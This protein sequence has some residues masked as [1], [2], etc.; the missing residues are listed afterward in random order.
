MAAA[1]RSIATLAA[2]AA[3]SLPLAALGLPLT[4]YLPNY[5]S[6]TLGLTVGMV[7][8][9]FLFVRL[10]DIAFDPFFGAVLDRTGWRM[11]RFKPWLAI[12]VPIVAAASAMLFMA[13]DGVGEL[14]LWAGLVV[15]YGGYSVCVLSHSAW[16]STLSTDYN[17]RSR[18]YAWWQTGNVVGMI[19]VIVLP[20][21]L[22]LWFRDKASLVAVF[23][24]D[25]MSKLSLDQAAYAARVRAMGWFIVIM[26]PLT[27][28]LAIRFVDE[29]RIKVRKDVKRANPADYLK[30]LKR[31]TVM[32][33]LTADLLMGLAPGIAGSL[34][35]FFFE[36]VKGFE[37][38][39]AEILLLVYFCAAV[40]GAPVWVR[41]SRKF[42]KH[43]VLIAASLV[44]AFVQFAVVTLPAGNFWLAVPFLILA[45]LPYSA[46]PFLLRAMLADVSDE[47]RLRTGVDRTG[48]LYAILV[49][50]VKIGSALA[51]STFIILGW[52]GFNAH[53]PAQSS[54]MGMNGLLVLYTM[55]PG[56]LGI[57]AAA[58]MIHYP[59][60]EARHA[61]IRAEL[62]GLEAAPPP[63]PEDLAVLQPNVA[64]NPAE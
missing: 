4:V 60:T 16:A 2:F 33:I 24:P 6:E 35:F 26:A 30:L 52:L 42:G 49:G 11:G 1:R 28:L 48:L 34:F 27:A 25:M 39:E 59:L 56:V 63:I 23:A 38:T 12:G 55:A 14:Y 62:D 20:V 5:Y 7:G 17:E 45:G 13:R 36:R 61:E 50:T 46:S 22:S 8:A 19:L 64:Q 29:P 53:D 21:L 31:P 9:A 15:V 18:V 58:A 57:L 3:P 32:R 54:Q 41:L 47:E 44:Y 51:V 40:A 43:R 10:F 37:K